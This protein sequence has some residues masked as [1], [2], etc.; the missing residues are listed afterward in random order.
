MA[1]HTAVAI[2]NEFL[3]LRQSSSIP[4]QMLIQKLAYIAHGWNLAING[5]PLIG[6]APEAWDNGPVYRTIWDAVKEYGYKGANR[7]ILDPSSEKPFSETLTNS[8]MSVVTHVWNKYGSMS[9]NKL[10]QLTHEPDTPWSKAYFDR[11][12]NATLN[13]QEIK[14]HYVALALAGRAQAQN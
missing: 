1:N 4:Q 3:K 10:S 11:G 7:E 14:D 2:A 6:E 8:E 9:A 5:E 12:R 13:N